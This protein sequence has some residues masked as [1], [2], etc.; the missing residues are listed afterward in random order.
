MNDMQKLVGYAENYQTEDFLALFTE[1]MKSEDPKLLLKKVNHLV[2]FIHQRPKKNSKKKNDFLKEIDDFFKKNKISSDFLN[3]IIF[4]ENAY[5]E[6]LLERDKIKGDL[7]SEKLL[8]AM[9]IG[10]I[11][12]AHN[13]NVH[14]NSILKKS[15]SFTEAMAFKGGPLGD[16]DPDG[17]I[18]STS[19]ILTDNLFLECYNNNW[20]SKEGIAIFPKEILEFM[21]EYNNNDQKNIK[22][23]N[24]LTKNT[25]LWDIVEEVDFCFRLLNEDI[26]FDNDKVKISRNNGLKYLDYANIAHY[27]ML[28]LNNFI[29]QLFFDYENFD[30]S[31]CK[32]LKFYHID[33]N[34]RYEY[35]GLTLKEWVKA[36]LILRNNINP[37]SCI[38]SYNKLFS[39]FRKNMGISYDKCKKLIDNLLFKKGSPDIFDTP[40]L[41][42]SNDQYLVVP[43]GVMAPNMTNIMNSILSK[44]DL[45]LKD[46][47][48]I[49]EKKVFDYFKNLEDKFNFKCKSQH[50][51]FKNKDEYQQ[52]EKDEYQFD[53][54]LEWD[55][56]IFI[57]ECKNRSIPNTYATSLQDFMQK[58]DEYVGQIKRLEDGLIK[59]SKEFGVDINS[60]EIVLVILNAQSFSLDFRIN[61][62]IFT[63]YS[64]IEDFFN[65]RYLTKYK[66]FG[67]TIQK[68]IVFDQWKGEKPTAETF[69][70]YISAPYQVTEAKEKIK[71][72]QTEHE[73]LQYK[74]VLDRS[75]IDYRP[76]Q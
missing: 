37:F 9:I 71:Y 49:F 20:F 72:S 32:F 47:G 43:I 60:K 54:L 75:N 14:L 56:F 70:A 74:I 67:N 69:L 66:S 52:N 2:N 22:L 15:K 41:K 12:S 35:C 23:V 8:C 38:F 55:D 21:K 29:E 36:F 44:N 48:G 50:K 73:I 30:L 31:D 40:I 24:D 62:V 58:A 13:L 11:I 33:I 4:F 42:F 68:C 59:Y 26:I 16:I 63:D 46:K 18:N 25:G 5:N 76:F 53:I 51:C 57:F 19:K 28:G 64:I 27:R 34:N 65:D 10:V 7:S 6:I 61:D 3:T 39:L 1:M 17:V 45:A